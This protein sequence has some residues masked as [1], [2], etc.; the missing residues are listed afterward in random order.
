MSVQ[1][2]LEISLSYAT[3]EKDFKKALIIMTFLFL[4]LLV[5]GGFWLFC[6]WYQNVSQKYRNISNSSDLRKN[7]KHRS[8][9]EH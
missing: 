2:L 9:V 7:V 3:G 4:Y 8:D 5:I 6:L 1:T